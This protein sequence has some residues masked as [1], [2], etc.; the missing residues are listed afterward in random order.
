MNIKDENILKKYGIVKKHVG[1]YYKLVFCSQTRTA[2]YFRKIK[3]KKAFKR[4]I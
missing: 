4:F 2:T 3:K 1:K